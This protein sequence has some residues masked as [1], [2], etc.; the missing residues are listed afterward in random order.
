MERKQPHEK[1]EQFAVEPL[2]LVPK[3]KP[4]PGPKPAIKLEPLD[5]SFNEVERDRY[6]YFISAVEKLFP[7][8]NPLD[9]LL[10]EMAA[11]EYVK[12]LRLLQYEVKN[13]TSITMARQHPGV[14]FRSL[15]DMLSVSRK[16]RQGTKQEDDPGRKEALEILK[17]LRTG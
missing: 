9:R 16:A 14:Q 8:L 3:E 13:N 6:L 11:V 15:I 7:D 4:K 5:I 1:P 17:G 12:Y 10:L 2:R